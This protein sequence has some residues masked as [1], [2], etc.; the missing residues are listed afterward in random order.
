MAVSVVFKKTP[1]NSLHTKNFLL[2]HKHRRIGGEYNSTVPIEEE[3]M[4]RHFRLLKG[5]SR[6]GAR[7][8]LVVLSS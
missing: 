5:R 8:V 2:I 7:A 4:V 6:V 3:R 1:P